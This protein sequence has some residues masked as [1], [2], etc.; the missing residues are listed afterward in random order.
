MLKNYLKIALRNLVKN[1]SHTLINIGGLTLGTVCVLVIFL[2]IQFDLSFDKWHQDSDR[3]YRVVKS[4]NEFGTIDYNRGGPYPLAE[5]VRNDISGIEAVTMIDNNASNTL[6]ISYFEEG[7]RLKR[8]KEQNVAFVHQ[9]FFDIFSYQWTGG[10]PG[11]AL[12]NPNSVILTESFAI[13]MFGNLNVIGK[14]IVLSEDLVYDLEITGVVKDPPKNS[15]FPFLLF[16]SIHSKDR[17][18]DDASND[19]WDSNSS[20]WQTY[21]KLKEGVHPDDVNSQF[22]PMIVKYIDEERAEVKEFFLQ[23]LSEIHF[24][25]RFGNYNERIVEKRTLYALGIIGLFLLI[26]A[27]INFI[28]LNTAIAV[29]R[30]KEV[31]L[32]K[33]LGGTKGQLIIHFLGETAFITLI[34]LLLGLGITEIVLHNIEP[35]LGFTP[36]LNILSDT[37]VIIFLSVLF[38]GITILAGWYPAQHLSS[39][40]P[41]EAIRNK[42]NTNY[43]QGLT[44]RRSLIIV[45]FTITQILIIGTLIIA[46]QIKLFQTQDLGIIEEALVEVNISPIEDIAFETLKNTLESESSILN[47]SFSN[48]GTASGNIWGGNYTLTDDTL[49]KRNDTQGKY[50]DEAFVE[51]YGLQ[52]LAGNNLIPSDTVTSYLVNET[53]AHQ[54]GY[55]DNYDGLLGKYVR[56]WGDEAPIVGVVKNFNTESLHT[57]LQPVVM[58]T[59]R[60]YYVLGIKI[61]MNRSEDALNAIEKAYTAAFPDFVFEYS[62]LDES[63]ASM[64]EGEERTANI[65]NAFTFVAILIGCLGL[66]GLIS[67]M[68]TARTKEI[69]VRKVLGASILDILR[70]FAFELSLLTGVS[71]IIAAPISY[72]LMDQW[73]NDF[74]YKIDIGLEI[75]AAA[76]LGTILIAGLTVGYKTIS[77]ALTN[78][79]ES[80]KSE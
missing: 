70:I 20:A 31:G 47:F 80:L 7:N 78:P 24:D 30:S 12:E 25:S 62:F 36:T 77:A 63:I 58:S 17:N 75:F 5:A 73:L 56:F 68:T 57:E 52:I 19:R 28:N 13:K 71:F 15:D 76:F 11:T 60:N 53:F 8:F 4:E 16:V 27:C 35:I 50:I 41:I 42:I 79:V 34:S 26:T 65:M 21:V 6:S 61:N 1:K 69:G 45:Q 74:A 29:T 39:F 48:T 66:F 72:Y 59:E 43:G 9:D 46:S 67:Y 32:R 55:G 14:N 3:I 51:T 18:N 23:P 33:T 44:L 49:Q 2:I 40:N 54:V 64:Y 38:F 10:N 37:S 22:D